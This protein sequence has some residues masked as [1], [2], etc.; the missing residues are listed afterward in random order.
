MITR[1][2]KIRVVIFISIILFLLLYVLFL[3]IGNKLMTK[4]DIYYIK[5]DKQSVTGLSVGQEVRYYGIKVG[6]IIKIGLDSKDMSQIV[7]TV[8][9]SS[10]F[11]VKENVVANLKMLGITGLKVVELTG[12]ASDGKTLKPGSTIFATEDAFESI[13][14]KAE[15]I[16]EKLEIMVNNIINLTKEENRS[17]VERILKNVADITS[18]SN[19][20]K[21]SL[22]L[23]NVSE[24]VE[25]IKKSSDSVNALIEGNKRKITQ[26]VDKM[27]DL[28][29]SLKKSAESLDKLIVNS[30]ELVSDKKIK[31]AIANF[32][33]IIAKFNTIDFKVLTDN[34]N[35]LINETKS[36]V[37]HFDET[38]V[39]INQDVI[40]SIKIF[41]DTLENLNDF[42][43]LIKENP[44]IILKGKK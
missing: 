10:D 8:T 39:R 6:K 14:G 29:L 38:F 36:A 40:E 24:S 43:Q 19:K 35:S 16:S 7:L 27:E 33:Q 22:L 4:E 37:T 31:D 42:S 18:D 9:I 5:L 2:Q 15:I 41:K 13:T 11:P 30:N 25:S 26:S 12:G 3:L 21:F 28:V 34:S 32:E 44:D 23:N 1:V 17:S 20:E